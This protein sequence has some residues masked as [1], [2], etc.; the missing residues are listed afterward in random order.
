MNMCPV[1][2][3]KVLQTGLFLVETMITKC[4]NLPNKMFKSV[5][6]NVQKYKTENPSGT[7]IN[8]VIEGFLVALARIELASKEP[9]SFILSIKL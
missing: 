7:L 5:L 1:C 3:F 9:E 8:S 4:S 6:Q 2:S